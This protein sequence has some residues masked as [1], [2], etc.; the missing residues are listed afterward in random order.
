MA[1]TADILDY[2]LS[3]MLFFL[4]SRNASGHLTVSSADIEVSLTINQGEIVAS[5][6]N[7]RR[8]RL[9]QRLVAA[10][11][12]SDEEL[13]TVIDHLTSHPGATTIGRAVVELGYLSAEDVQAAL[14]A[15]WTEQL[16]QILIRGQEGRFTFEP[17]PTSLQGITADIGAQGLVFEAMRR[18]D[19]WLDEQLRTQPLHIADQV[20]QEHSDLVS[21]DDIRILHLLALGPMNA[22][23][24]S[25]WLNVEMETVVTSLH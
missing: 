22:K 18:A 1:I 20:D 13:V 3:E 23:Y 4:S 2:P 7:D 6:S 9:G 25:S 8:Q 12:I 24:L 10:G 14:Q 11:A 21:L 19:E 5:E 15:Q 16:F 17:G